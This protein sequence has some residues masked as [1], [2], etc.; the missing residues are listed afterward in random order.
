[1]SRKARGAAT[2]RLVALWFRERGWPY[3]TDIGAGRSGVDVENMPGLA[4]EVKARRDLD[5]TG[6]LRQATRNAGTSLPFVVHRPDGY[7]PAS[8]GEWPVTLPLK[9]F[10]QLLIDAG[11]GDGQKEETA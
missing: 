5:L 10:T 2:Q 1:M 6:W 3:A 4:P 8:I 7:G 9:H 11:Y